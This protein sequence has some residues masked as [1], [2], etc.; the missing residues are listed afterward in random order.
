[1]IEM[2][3][4]ING[5]RDDCIRNIGVIDGIRRQFDVLEDINCDNMGEEEYENTITSA[6]DLLVEAMDILKHK[7]AYYDQILA[8]DTGLIEDYYYE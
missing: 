5:L 4:I 3:T 7:I 1:M 8:G 2:K 6:E